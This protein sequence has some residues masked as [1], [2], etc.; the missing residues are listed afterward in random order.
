M[1]N[2]STRTNL[3]QMSRFEQTR[4]SS[5]TQETELVRRLALLNVVAHLNP[6]TTTEEKAKFDVMIDSCPYPWMYKPGDTI[7]VKWDKKSGETGNVAVEW[8]AMKHSTAQFV[9]YY[10]EHFDTFFEQTRETILLKL[11]YNHEVTQRWIEKPCGDVF[12]HNGKPQ[13]N[14]NTLI[15]TLQFIE[16]LKAL[17]RLPQD[18]CTII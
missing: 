2:P 10:L 3:F 8:E 1:L 9:S 17:R 4:D 14:M 15:P 6:A 13:Q 16:G 12:V 11:W 5:T 7:E 18:V